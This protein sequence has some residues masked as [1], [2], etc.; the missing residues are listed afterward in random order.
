MSRVLG[1][2]W[3]HRDERDEKGSLFPS[4]IY[5]QRRGTY[6]CSVLDILI[7]LAGYSRL[8]QETSRAQEGFPIAS[9]RSWDRGH[10]RITRDASNDEHTLDPE[11]KRA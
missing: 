5:K 4:V 6:G 2:Q 3:H 7:N 9:L 1:L 8:W 10:H 11:P